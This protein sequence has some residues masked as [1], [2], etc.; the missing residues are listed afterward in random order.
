ME[1]KNL[2]ERAD[3]LEKQRNDSEARYR[4]LTQDYEK[5]AD[6]KVELQE[7]FERKSREK[8]ITNETLLG[9]QAKNTELKNE[10]ARLSAPKFTTPKSQKPRRSQSADANTS[11]RRQAAS[12]AASSASSRAS[13]ESRSSK[14]E[15]SAKV[16]E[17]K[18]GDRLKVQELREVGKALGKRVVE[19][20][21][22]VIEEDS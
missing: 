20:N 16:S 6:E 10:K 4:A 18:G 13:S 9:V 21:Q 3:I 14:G 17:P 2:E 22:D 7:K 1:K 11:P 15:V 8:E 12:S 19:G 5:V